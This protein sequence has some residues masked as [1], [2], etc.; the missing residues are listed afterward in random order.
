MKL[1]LTT[2]RVG[3]GFRLNIIFAI[4]CLWTFRSLSDIAIGL[5]IVKDR[6]C[7]WFDVMLFTFRL[8]PGLCFPTF[9]KSLVDMASACIQDAVNQCAIGDQGR[10]SRQQGLYSLFHCTT[11][12]YSGTM[13]I[14]LCF[15]WTKWSD[16]LFSIS[17][18][19]IQG[20]AFSYTHV[21]KTEKTLKCMRT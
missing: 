13:D 14:Q 5:I 21:L 9:S 16:V 3:F 18:A 6:Y 10:L 15:L 4:K 8:H 11:R 2:E 1:S 20:S 12:R 19:L 7:W 17:K